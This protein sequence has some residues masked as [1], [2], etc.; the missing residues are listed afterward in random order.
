MIDKS[1]LRSNGWSEELIRAAESI[2]TTVAGSAVVG[3][4]TTGIWTDSLM[5]TTTSSG[6][7]VAD[8]SGPPVAQPQLLIP[9][10]R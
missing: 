3:S 1:F 2:A 7:H 8:V 6:S 4:Y 5:T 10:G 9:F